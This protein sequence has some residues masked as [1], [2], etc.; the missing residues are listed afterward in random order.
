MFVSLLS[1]DFLLFA[2]AV[3]VF[4]AS[5]TGRL[6]EIGFLVANVG[7]VYAVI[8]ASSLVST[9]LFCL[10]GWLLTRTL[11]SKSGQFA[12]LS[13]TLLIAVFIYIRDYEF[14]GW[15]VSEDYRL[16][17]LQ[18]VGL[19]FLL[20]RILHVM[21]DARAGVIERI[22]P[23]TYFNYLLAF[24]T[25]MMGPIQRFED[26]KR[27]WSDRTLA[28][29]MDFEAHI[30]A[31]LRVLWGFTK[32]YIIGDFIHRFALQPDTNVLALSAADLWI[33]LAGFYFFLYMN[34]S[35]YCDIVIGLGSLMG[36]RPPENFNHPYLAQNISDF[37]LRQHRSLTLWL[38]DYVFNPVYKWALSSSP[39]SASPLFAGVFAAMLTM[40]VSGIWHG[41]TIGFLIF[42]V[43]HG[44]W[45]ALYRIWDHVLTARFGRKRLRELRASWIGRILGIALT[46]HAAALAFLF[47]QLDTPHVIQLIEKVF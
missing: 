28:I 39:M 24:T 44:V 9:I 45:L 32:V 29:P 16:S 5:T 47:F 21:I 2:T 27:Q 1:A 40:F 33:Q 31:T 41:T 22:D 12:V 11:I 13:S 19:S 34:F 3:V 46:F 43:V 23:L 10:L 14:I 4:V 42:G 30:D 20:F 18:T 7:F 17:I 6:R 26:F 35:G 8:G 25:F 36:I 15:F 38:T 37:W